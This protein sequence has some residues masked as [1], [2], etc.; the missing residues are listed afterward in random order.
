MLFSD[1]TIFPLPPYFLSIEY[2]PGPVKKIVINAIKYI[3]DFSF[4][5]NGSPSWLITKATNIV[6]IGKILNKRVL[7][8]IIKN[9]G[10]TNSANAV[11]K[12]DNVEPIPIGSENL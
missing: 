3:N 6:I 7:N 9:I 11:R 5:E 10:A 1:N 4:L 8:P 2:F 12:R